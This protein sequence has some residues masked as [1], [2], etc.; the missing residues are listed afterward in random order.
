MNKTQEMFGVPSYGAIKKV[1][2]YMVERVQDFITR[3][4]FLVMASCNAL[5]HSDAS[6]RGGKSGFVKVIDEKHLVI[7]DIS[8]NK[9]FQ[10]YE[11]IETN[12]YIGLIFF[13]P[14][15]KETVRVN[16]KVRIL[17]K[18]DPEFDKLIVEVF[19]PDYNESL[20][21]ALML[22]VVESYSHCSRALSFSMLWDTSVIKSNQ[23]DTLTPKTDS[24]FR[25][26]TNQFRRIKNGLYS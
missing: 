3:S 5:G 18:G 12:P 10:S 23:G 24:C 14:G 26:L 1:R 22:E 21:Q 2:S 15:I 4:P 20:L 16:G 13:I 7:P 6:P 8:G 17:K 19:E 11:N 25:K 9:L